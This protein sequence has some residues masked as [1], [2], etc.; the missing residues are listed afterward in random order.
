M[1]EN[2]IL[3]TVSLLDPSSRF[4]SRCGARILTLLVLLAGTPVA[5]APPLGDLTI[6]ASRVP[7]WYLP[8]PV[9]TSGWRVTKVH[10]TDCRDTTTNDQAALQSA[11]NAA[12]ANTV[13]EL[14]ASCTYNLVSGTLRIEKSNLVLRGAGIASTTIKV[15]HTS[16]FSGGSLCSQSFIGICGPDDPGAEVNWTAGYAAGARDVTVANGSGFAVGDWVHLQAAFPTEFLEGDAASG[17]NRAENTYIARVASKPSANV[18]RLD[19]GLR[20]DFSNARA[21]QQVVLEL[22]PIRNVGL[23][24]LRVTPTDRT[25]SGYSY[26]PAIA[27]GNAVDSWI[28]DVKVDG[29]YNVMITT[30]D[31]ARNLYERLWLTDLYFHPWNEA[32]FEFN[33]SAVDSVV[34]NSVF[35]RNYVDVK[36]QKGASGNAWLYNYHRRAGIDECHVKSTSGSETAGLERAIFFHGLANE[37]L[38]EGNDTG[39]SIEMDQFWG[40]Q[41]YRNTFYRNRAGLSAPSANARDYGFTTEIR[42][43]DQPVAFY[44]NFMLNVASSFHSKDGPDT[45]IDNIDRTVPVQAMWFE[46]NLTMGALAVLPRTDT[47]RTNNRENAGSTAWSGFSAPASLL[48]VSGKPSW[49]LSAPWPGVGADVDVIGGTLHKLPAQCRFE[50]STTGVCGASPGGGAPPAPPVLLP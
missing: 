45:Q 49:W 27:V 19:R 40:T 4:A 23:E 15:H 14:D 6:P 22:H 7:T 21:F 35:V 44:P 36:F 50:G 1:P 28:R 16:G 17:P 37:T 31:A 29:W 48:Y 39:C 24:S 13:L 30:R 43:H 2:S 33:G 5:A 26:K 34:Q 46:R 12:G 41:G 18:L 9:D 42:Q 3:M 25:N 32:A 38:V 8:V 20:S 10:A 47:T 11:I